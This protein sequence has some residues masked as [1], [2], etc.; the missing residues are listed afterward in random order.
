M[1]PV[2]ELN[3]RQIFEL[4]DKKTDLDEDGKRKSLLFA[5]GVRHCWNPEKKCFENLILDYHRNGTGPLQIKYPGGCS[6]LNETIIETLTREMITETGR[7]MK[8]DSQI[9]HYNPLLNRKNGELE[10]LQVFFE[11][12]I[13]FANRSLFLKTKT[14]SDNNECSPVYWE[15]I[16]QKLVD[17]MFRSHK[18]PLKKLIR[19]LQDSVTDDDV[20]KYAK[21][22][23]L[24]INI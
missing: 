11:Q 12:E 2:L 19:K 6:E 1:R 16:S 5:S 9:L 3:A 20:E 21:L 8:K 23:S 10:H 22:H 14:G 24:A 13:A 7:P 4:V 17:T 18:D 15:P